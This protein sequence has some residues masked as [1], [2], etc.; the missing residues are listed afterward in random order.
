MVPNCIF[1]PRTLGCH[2]HLLLVMPPLKKDA[3]VME[4]T[5]HHSTCPKQPRIYEQ[6][7]QKKKKKSKV[8]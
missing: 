7:P 8:K 2:K 1:T 5:C 3:Q 4:A 6:L